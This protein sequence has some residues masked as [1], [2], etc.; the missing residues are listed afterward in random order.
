MNK[1]H[2][3]NFLDWFVPLSPKINLRAH[4]LWKW[5]EL[6]SS[7]CSRKAERDLCNHHGVCCGFVEISAVFKFLGF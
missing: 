2:L 4:Y 5:N 1:R 7:I 3:V 6:L